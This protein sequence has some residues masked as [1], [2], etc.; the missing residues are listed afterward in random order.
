MTRALIPAVLMLVAFGAVAL[1]RPHLSATPTDLHLIAQ[2]SPSDV[3]SVLD[4]LKATYKEQKEVD[5]TTVF[6]VSG[7]RDSILIYLHRDGNAGFVTSLEATT[8]YSVKDKLSVSAA[9]DWN[10][11]NRFSRCSI[12]ADGRPTLATD[13]I[14]G[15]GITR[16][17]LSA[18]VNLFLMTAKKFEAETL[19]KRGL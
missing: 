8:T 15:S 12:D 17:S 3:R 4:E 5:G 19:A 2:V 9:N 1:A 6:L 14:V 16:E 18:S 11:S 13:V 7:P 10:S